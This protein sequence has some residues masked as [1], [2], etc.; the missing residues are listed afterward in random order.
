MAKNRS[1]FTIRGSRLTGY[2]GQG[3]EGALTPGGNFQP[4]G[5]HRVREK[6][7]QSSSPRGEGLVPD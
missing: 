7:I 1:R 3:A 2:G 6:R 5:S 4:E